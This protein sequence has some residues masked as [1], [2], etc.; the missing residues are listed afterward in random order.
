MKIR[1][2]Q[3]LY[4]P[5][6]LANHI[7]C[8]HLT[9]LNKKEVRGDIDPPEIY[10]NP[11]LTRLIDRGIAFEQEYLNQLKSQ[12]LSVMEIEYGE[13]DAEKKTM[14][15]IANG[16][17][18][19]YQARLKSKKWSGWADFLI[20][21]EKPSDLGDWSYQ[22]WDTKLA[23]NTRAS[24]ILQVGLYTQRLSEIQGIDPEFMGV[25]KPNG[26][27][28]FRYH[29]FAA[30]IRLVQQSLEGSLLV[31]S[32][33]YPDPVSHCE[34]CKWWKK[35]NAQRRND[36]HLTFVAGMGKPQM[37]ELGKNNLNTLAKLA[38]MP[39]PLPISP[40]N[41]S[42]ATFNKLRNQAKIQYESR[43]KGFKPLHDFLPIEEGRGFY[44][45][46]EPNEH[47]VY[48]D[49][50]GARMV[51]PNGLEY[52]IGYIYEGDY[53]SLWATNEEQ[54]LANFEKFIDWIHE[55]KGSHPKM[56]IYHY[57]PY[58]PSAFKRIMGKYAS[59]ENEVD[60][61]LRSKS[62]V[63]LYRILRQSLIASVERY[64]LK[65]LEK[66]FG[67]ERKMDLRKVSIPKTSFEYLLEIKREGEASEFDLWIIEQYNKD[68][69]HALIELQKWLES[70]RNELIEQ[71]LEITR[72]ELAEGIASDKIT[73]HQERIE[74]LF[75]N[76][77]QNMPISEQDRS[78]VEQGR[79][80]L[81]HFLDWYRREEKAL[82]WEYFRLIE[83]DPEELLDERKAISFL[84]YSGKSYQEKRSRVDVYTFPP[85]EVDIKEEAIKNTDGESVGTIHSVDKDNGILEIKKGPKFQQL[86]HPSGL[87]QLQRINPTEK[88][89][90]I[91]RLAQ[92]VAE[93]SIDSKDHQYLLGR[94]LLLRNAP[95]I[96]VQESNQNNIDFA[97]E[98]IKGLNGDYLAIQGPPGS[99]K[100]YTGSHLILELV[101]K[102]KKI[103]VTAMSHKV[104]TNLVAKTNELAISED[105]QLNIIQKG[106]SDDTVPWAV[107]DNN[108][109]ISENLNDYQIIAGTSFMWAREEF[110][111]S[112]D[113]M[114]VDE[115]GQLA[116]IDTIAL[117]QCAS[118]M[119]L[120]GDPNQLQQP[121]QG[122]HPAGTQ[123]SALE[124][125]LDGNQTIQ[126]DQ[127]IF[128]ETTWRMHPAIND[129]VSEL[130]Y[131]NR[132]I[133]EPHLGEQSLS[134]N[135]KYKVGL[136]LLEVDHEGNSSS[137]SEEVRLITELVNQ[138]C[139][140]SIGYVSVEENE[141][142]ISKED[143][144]IISPYNAQVNLLKKEIPNVEIGTVDKFQGQEAPIVIYSVASSSPLEAP[145]GMEFLYSPNRLNVAISRA[146]VLF[147]MVASPKIFEADCKSPR[148]MK[149]ANAYCRFREMAHIL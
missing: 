131:Q 92:W 109:D 125:I 133:T 11:S 48:L 33:T 97:I 146:K 51:E 106:G 80:I 113:Y 71:G 105:I 29:D 39:N 75:I 118:N 120:L 90:S 31:D 137:S 72:P 111:E 23:T 60:E 13:I 94:N 99:G 18:I 20:K 59:R 76:L 61:L 43:E 102:G 126:M 24:T 119:I 149:L 55:L 101:K 42:L 49:L 86:D 114:V 134:G 12:G 148:E 15:A 147:I 25:I 52:L 47:D 68:D 144:K 40:E 123:V 78:A 4:S 128:L 7:S 22:V 115:A 79:Y 74:P 64:S 112:V 83:L 135:L 142:T 127:G 26:E 139:S 3:I 57:A 85:Q 116:L 141:K 37:V 107:S 38:S 21:V 81:A 62:F 95:H 84:S 63:D 46:P 136:S 65:D 58:E 82:W 69:C 122:V 35:C 14:D 10:N 9:E 130:F 32:E 27:E 117:S 91:I 8:R 96:H 132:L 28:I 53:T 89:E 50:E 2:N 67:Y 19:I 77:M 56:H 100:S 45:L 41:G 1:E 30:Y 44:N 108:N 66:F 16:Y 121:Q 140:G 129:I 103:G 5:S 70:L 138:L 93:N 6:D 98:I 73:E 88:E 54:E 34:I 143:L 17:D 104:I 124:H 87:I 36:D 145:R 110:Y